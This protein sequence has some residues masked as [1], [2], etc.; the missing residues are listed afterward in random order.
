MSA[1]TLVQR[2]CLATAAAV[3][4]AHLNNGLLP[5]DVEQNMINMLVEAGE[6]SLAGGVSAFIEPGC[7]EHDIVHICLA[8]HDPDLNSYMTSWIGVEPITGEV[9]KY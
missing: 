3:V 1:L 9:I 2:D 4:L 6:L 8:D 7:A 5:L